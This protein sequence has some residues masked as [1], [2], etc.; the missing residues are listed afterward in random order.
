MSG[1]WGVYTVRAIRAI[2]AIR[3]VWTYNPDKIRETN[4]PR[5]SCL[6]YFLELIR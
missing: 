3:K 4:Y 5:E 2:R 1:S 6:G